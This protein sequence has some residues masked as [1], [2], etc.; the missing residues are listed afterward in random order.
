MYT[1]ARPSC[2]VLS[3]VSDFSVAQGELLGSPNGQVRLELR[4]AYGGPTHI[5]MRCPS[6]YFR[7][8]IIREVYDLPRVHGSSGHRECCATFANAEAATETPVSHAVK[9]AAAARESTHTTKHTMTRRKRARR[10]R[11]SQNASELGRAQQY[12]ARAER[13]RTERGRTRRTRQ[14]A[15]NTQN[16]A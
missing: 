5:P 14:S 7:S 11:T 13:G 3:A 16:A 9:M 12:T 6:T 15:Q 1:R 2:G 8:L 4:F 10:G